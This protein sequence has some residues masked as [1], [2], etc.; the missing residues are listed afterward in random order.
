MSTF[1][2]MALLSDDGGVGGFLCG[3]PSSLVR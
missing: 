3:F 2:M 1:G